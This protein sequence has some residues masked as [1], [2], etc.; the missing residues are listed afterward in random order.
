MYIIFT[1]N[2][3]FED[4]GPK[5]NQEELKSIPSVKNGKV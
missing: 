3:K 2:L 1:G 4:L 5:N